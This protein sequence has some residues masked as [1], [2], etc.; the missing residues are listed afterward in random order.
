MNRFSFF[1]INR[2]QT[3]LSAFLSLLNVKHTKAYADKL[4]NEHPY[5]YSL[6]GLSKMLSE[7]QIQNVGVNFSNKEI[8]LNE[9]EVPFIAHAGNEFVLVYEKND[10]KV[11]YLWQGKQIDIAIDYFKQIWSGVVL[12][13]E[14]DKDSIEP[15]YA[16]SYKKEWLGRIKT[17]VLLLIISS[18][19]VFS[20]IEIKV[21]SNLGIFFS[22]LANFVG[23]YV[24]ILLL[25]KQIHVQSVYADKICSLFKK[26]DCNNILES[27]DAKLWG[28]IGWS[29]IGFGYFISNL[30]VI[31]WF[32]Y[33]M[34]YSILIGCAAL[35]FSF[36]SIWYQKVKVK[37]WCPLCLIVQLLFWFLFVSYL[38]SGLFIIPLFTM[39]H[40]FI[41]GCI[42]SLPMLLTSFI[43]PQLGKD[44]KMQN[45]IQQTNSLKMKD[46]VIVALL[47]KQPYHKVDKTTSKIIFGNPHASI[48]LTILTNPHC[49]PCG[50]MHRRMEKLLEKVGEK[51]CVQYIF[52]S[53]N[54]ELEGSNKQLI[55]V[56]LNHTIEESCKIFHDWFTGGKYK[57]ED[58][59]QRYPYDREDE[60]VEKEFVNHNKWKE[61]AGLTATPTILINGY[62]LPRDYH[63]EDIVYFVDI[64]DMQTL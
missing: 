31:F 17:L 52:S 29:E 7:Y 13:A 21:F 64:E 45:L 55:A 22:V 10:K 26:S 2:N 1:Y 36:W 51:I 16:I 42:Y 43:C 38:I 30:I 60:K 6:F 25:M 44:S 27:K 33:L 57:R 3:I 54:E 34:G 37:Q 28:I 63:I 11:S 61:R 50:F 58:F 56:Y 15:N 5:K 23:I 4:Y 46:E 59:Y 12:L 14:P 48:R 32:P 24:C 9:L 39:E 19:F 40:L 47:K 35:F 49:E 53:F 18:L 8:G 41:V 62:V 20:C